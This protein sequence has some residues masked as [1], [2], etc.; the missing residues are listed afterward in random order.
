MTIENIALSV[1]PTQK[2]CLGATL[3]MQFFI[4]S[5]FKQSLLVCFG[6]MSWDFRIEKFPNPT[7][8]A[9]LTHVQVKQHLQHH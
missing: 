5:F 9:I 2:V 4:C 8:L 3:P 1:K 7:C 6:L